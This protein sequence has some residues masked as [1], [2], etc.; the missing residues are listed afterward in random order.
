MK[1]G[2]SINT[3]VAVSAIVFMG[4]LTTVIAF[5][6]YTL[7]YDSVME[8]YETYTNTVS[9]YAYRTAEKYSFG[10]MIAARDMPEGFEKMRSELNSV[11]ECS[12]IEYLYAIY[13]EDINDIHS[14]HYAINAKTQA[15]L[16][17][18]RPASEMYTYMGKPCEEGSFED[19]T[20][21]ILQEAITSR[22][23]DGGILEGWSE[24]YGHMLNGYRVIYDSGDN[25]VGFIC[26]EI[27]I[28]RINT[29]VNNYVHLV[30]V[31]AVIF[32]AVIIVIYLFSIHRYLIAPILSIAKS[33]DSFVKKMD[34]GAQPEELIY[35]AVHIRS[36]RELCVLADDVKSLADGVAA[37]M[38]NLKA[39]TAEKER[40]GAELSLATSIQCG[41]LP[42]K[43]PPFP[44]RTEFDI[45][46]SMDPAKE[47]GG[48]FYD[49]FLT[50]DDH[51]AV[52]IADVSGKGVPAALFMMSSKI[53]INDH[54]LMGG[55]PAE[56]LE[57]VN[58]QVCSQNRAEMFVTVWL[59]I[60]E[61]STGKLT[62]A[63]AGHE[64]PMLEQN[65]RFGLFMDKHGLAVGVMEIAKYKDYEI[66]L[67]KGD[68]IFVYTDGVAEAT[69]ANDRLF[70]TDRT[71]EALNSAPDA[72]PEQILKNVRAAVD[73]FVKEAPQFDDLTMLCL[74]YHGAGMINN[75]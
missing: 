25:A 30:I 45:Y 52:V 8:S 39:V 49:F 65:G 32:T 31:T 61:I 23:R 29:D 4:I 53:L 36:S 58:R 27:D 67:N 42:D 7:F 66:T 44:E 47:V 20:L 40:I 22:K 43:F 59:G 10:D 68:S 13:F 34:S 37:Y 17:T 3:R 14:L 21:L 15:E 72:A 51:L 46:A 1:K 16:S 24:E 18:G 38:T 2:I 54:A 12:E 62:A 60:L 19:D 35:E 75:E 11:K 63:S 5:I 55:T 33:S 6:G 71:L 70:G 56:I 74:R 50:D 26:V 64:Y 41:V 9:G 69:D 57:R 73:G 48:D 28:N